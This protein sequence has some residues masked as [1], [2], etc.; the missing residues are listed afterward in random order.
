MLLF[1]LCKHCVSLPHSLWVMSPH[2]I[3]WAGRSQPPSHSTPTPEICRLQEETAQ[4]IIK[5]SIDTSTSISGKP[6]TGQVM[7]QQMSLWNLFFFQSVNFLHWFLIF[8]FFKIDGSMW[9]WDL[10][11]FFPYH[12]NKVHFIPR[13]SQVG[14]KSCPLRHPSRY[15]TTFYI[16]TPF[17]SLFLS[18]SL[19]LVRSR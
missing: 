9:L 2:I 14:R 4:L 12:D 11:G 5:W 19:F 18:L 15:I 3:I 1:C 16:T 6:D 8:I 7:S 10:V 13:D 17:P